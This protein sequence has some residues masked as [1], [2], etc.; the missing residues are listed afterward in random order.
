MLVPSPHNCDR[1]RHPFLSVVLF[2]VADPR[3]GRGLRKSAVNKDKEVCILDLALN[4]RRRWFVLCASLWSAG[5]KWSDTVQEAAEEG[6]AGRRAAGFDTLFLACRQ[7]C[8]PVPYLNL[9]CAL[10][11]SQAINVSSCISTNDARDSRDDGSLFFFLSA[12]PAV[13]AD[14]HFRLLRN[15][16]RRHRT[17]SRCHDI[18]RDTS[19]CMT[20]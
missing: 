15:G 11:Y 5:E 6:D 4:L 17:T 1:H 7:F 3:Q 8:W 10:H 16:R 2:S 19:I 12:L 18:V 14:L 20:N 13:R 9:H